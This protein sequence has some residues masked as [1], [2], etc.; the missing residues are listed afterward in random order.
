MNLFPAG[1][2][3]I[4]ALQWF[5]YGQYH[6]PKQML[7]SICCIGICT[8]HTDIW[9]GLVLHKSNILGIS[10]YLLY[11]YRVLKQSAASPFARH[12]NLNN[13]SVFTYALYCE[14]TIANVTLSEKKTFWALEQ[15]RN[16]HCWNISWKIVGA[17]GLYSDRGY[18]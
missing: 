3:N 6:S 11:T 1:T 8:L 10:R 7:E 2:I 5:A 9:H 4:S 16:V 12:F 13:I 18:K 17:W 15:V 14:L